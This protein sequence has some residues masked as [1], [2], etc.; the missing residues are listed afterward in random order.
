MPLGALISTLSVIHI[1]AGGNM[2]AQ[3]IDVAE[4][5]WQLLG[6]KTLLRG[7]LLSEMLTFREEM[8]LHSAGVSGYGLGVMN[9]TSMLPWGFAEEGGLSSRFC[10]CAH[11]RPFVLHR[12]VLWAQRID[13]WLWRAVGL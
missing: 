13:V 12:A 7:S 1:Y 10:A 2:V 6:T 5:F 11:V 8:Y 3:P 4:F 9:F